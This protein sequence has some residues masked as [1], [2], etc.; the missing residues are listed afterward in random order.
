V[1]SAAEL[2]VLAFTLAPVLAKM[3]VPTPAIS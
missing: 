2:S 1:A 3:L